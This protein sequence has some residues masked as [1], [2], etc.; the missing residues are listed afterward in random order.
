MKKTILES[1]IKNT[2]EKISLIEKN[3]HPVFKSELSKLNR[4]LIQ[5]QH[6][7]DTLPAPLKEKPVKLK[8]DL[9]RVSKSVVRRKK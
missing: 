3:N 1:K 6:T 4:E 5:L 7:L 9:K 8:A 2:K